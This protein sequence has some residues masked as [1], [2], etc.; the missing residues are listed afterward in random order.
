MS[1]NGGGIGDKWAESYRKANEFISKLNRTERVN[2]LFGTENMM[3]VS[4]V[5]VGRKDFDHHCEGEID[6]FEND[7]VYFKTICFKDGS[8]GIRLA[9]GT[10]ISWQSNLNL[11]GTFNK[12]LIYEVGKALGEEA[13]EKGVNVLLS[14]NVN[15]LRTPQVGE[16]GK[17]MEMIR[18]M[19]VPA[20]LNL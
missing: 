8:T 7:Q 20:P 5:K 10:S 14:T 1:N 15:I 2:L 12:E 13:R 3:K 6:A 16:Y 11:A 18:F 4:N 19:L 9:N 17:P